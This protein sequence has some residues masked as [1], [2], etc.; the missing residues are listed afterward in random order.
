MSAGLFAMPVVITVC[1]CALVWSCRCLLP[2]AFV[3]IFICSH[4]PLI[5]IYI[6]FSSLFASFGVRSQS[7]HLFTMR[8]WK[9]KSHLVAEE[10]PTENPFIYIC[11]CVSRME[12]K[13]KK[14]RTKHPK[15]K[16]REK[17]HQQQHKVISQKRMRTE[18]KKGNSNILKTLIGNVLAA[19]KTVC[20]GE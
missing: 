18:G 3:V 17:K 16:R 8:I 9:T 20:E 14:T 1:C 11:V 6:Y 12:R 10:K 2:F 4:S 19:Y 15:L 13:R 7:L 5:Y